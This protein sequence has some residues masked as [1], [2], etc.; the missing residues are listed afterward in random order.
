MR[1]GARTRRARRFSPCSI[2]STETLINA[3]DIFD[4]F[5]PSSGL[6]GCAG[7]GEGLVEALIEIVVVVVVVVVVERNTRTL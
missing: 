6:S 2:V 4:E 3:R 5:R 1:H 7:K